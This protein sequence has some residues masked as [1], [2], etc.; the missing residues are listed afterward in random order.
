MP[1]IAFVNGKWSRLSAAKISIEDRG[2]QF[3][4]GVYEVIR[5]YG[6]EA[7]GLKEH[8][9]RLKTSAGEIE[10]PI[11]YSTAQ[12]ETFIRLGC[13]RSKFS[14][15]NIYI[16]LT[17]GAAP[18]N[19][20]FPKT[21][22]PTLVMTFRETIKISTEV[23]EKGV[24]VIS[25]PDIRWGRCHI[26]SLNLLPN[27]MAR[28]AAKRADAFEAL[29]I[30]DGF[31]TEGAGSNVFAVLGKRVLTPPVSPFLLSG[32]TR[33]LVIKLG[34]KAGLEMVEE[35]LRLQD[36]KTADELFLTGTT[37]EV[38]PV[39]ALDNRSIGSGCPG[40]TTAILYNAFQNYVQKTS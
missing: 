4:D 14:D 35:Q 12:L 18:R 6:Q 30:R 20:P 17:R 37:V 10:I 11:P 25:L 1:N 31:V 19:H 24:A 28:E 26:K 36:L 40:K 38:L 23:R 15:T 8:L 13:Q 32:V 22:R 27:I 16:Q 5:T 2:F 29:L 7:F 39:I 3:G 33:D 34:K 21:V 9:N